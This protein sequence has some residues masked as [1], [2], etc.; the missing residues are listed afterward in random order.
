MNWARRMI[1]LTARVD[2]GV[3]LPITPAF[4]SSQD[5][6][7]LFPCVALFSFLQFQGSKAFGMAACADECKIFHT[8]GLVLA[9]NDVIL[10]EIKMVG[11]QASQLLEGRCLTSCVFLLD[12]ILVSCFSCDLELVKARKGSVLNHAFLIMVFY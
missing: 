2:L 6:P 8:G 1:A 3:A 4:H 12:I 9:W 10:K 5:F 11:T 7:P